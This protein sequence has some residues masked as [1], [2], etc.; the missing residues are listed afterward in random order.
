VG[1]FELMALQS[2]ATASM[3]ECVRIFE[4]GLRHYRVREW[5]AAIAHFEQSAKLEPIQPGAAPEIHG[6]PSLVFAEL[7]A[8]WREK[9]PM[10][11]GYPFMMS[12]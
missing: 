3:R 10:G 8:Q 1:I 2:A 4:N 12:E 5:D 9:P 6:N 7:A 11:D